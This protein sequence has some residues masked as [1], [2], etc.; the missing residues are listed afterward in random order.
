MVFVACLLMDLAYNGI[1]KNERSLLVI[2]YSS[3]T[4]FSA[5]TAF[6]TSMKL[7]FIN[8][9]FKYNISNTKAYF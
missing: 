2:I 5:F 3:E 9:G 7:P 1:L 4:T 6:R 8:A